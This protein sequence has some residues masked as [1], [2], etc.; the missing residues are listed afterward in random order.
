[1]LFL[2]KYPSTQANN[3]RA[4]KTIENNSYEN[5]LETHYNVNET[6]IR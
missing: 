3:S 1:M 2:D 4:I 5:A 6:K